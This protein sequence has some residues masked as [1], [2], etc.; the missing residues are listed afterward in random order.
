MTDPEA[1][2]RSSGVWAVV[3]RT[4]LLIVGGLLTLV[5]LVLL[6]LPGPGIPLVIAGLAVLAPE[7]PWAQRHR[8]RITDA[9]RRVLRRSSPNAQ[10]G[11]GGSGPDESATP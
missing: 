11:P 8:D 10:P 3:R 7:F 2:S 1:P 4:G 6:V 5:G 9:G